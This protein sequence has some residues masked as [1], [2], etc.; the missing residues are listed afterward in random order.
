MIASSSSEAV[1]SGL[2]TVKSR[3]KGAF[4][5]LRLTGS[6]GSKEKLFSKSDAPVPL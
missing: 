4:R 2:G 6:E 3:S 1:D 5:A